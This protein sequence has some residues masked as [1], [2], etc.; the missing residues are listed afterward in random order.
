MLTFKLRMVAFVLVGLSGAFV[1]PGCVAATD[2]GGT[3]GGASGGAGEG[4][5]AVG[6]AV[7]ADTA[8][9]CCPNTVSGDPVK[10]ST[11]YSDHCPPYY[12]LSSQGPCSPPPDPDKICSASG[13]AGAGADPIGMGPAFL[14]ALAFG[15]MRRHSRR[16]A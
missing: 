7:Q 9:C 10:C 3:G 2:D 16:V 15:A 5:E 1:A 4:G 14:L 8:V 11:V 13:H 12:L 6:E